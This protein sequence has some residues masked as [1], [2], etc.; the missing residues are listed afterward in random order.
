MRLLI[1]IGE[2]SGARLIAELD[3]I[4]PLRGQEVVLAHVIDTG[5]RG[6]LGLLRERRHPARPMPGRRARDIGDAERDAAARALAEARAAA[7]RV[8]AKV[9]AGVIGEGE[10][11]RLVSALAADHHCL[12]VALASREERSP[13]EKAGPHSVGH[14]ARFVLDHSPCPV[15]LVRGAT[16]VPGRS[17]SG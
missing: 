11:G 15:L 9:V 16:P 14:T 8:G 17:N 13:D 3:R 6:E 7:E 5:A 10:P 12:L 2:R 1:G 4:L